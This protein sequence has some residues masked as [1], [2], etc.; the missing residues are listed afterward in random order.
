VR[1]YMVSALARGAAAYAESGQ[2][3]VCRGTLNPTG[4]GEG[5][6]RI[7]DAMVDEETRMGLHT[8]EGAERMKASLRESIKTVG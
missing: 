7:F 3:H 1:E 4:P 2:Y 5:F 8:P 6:V